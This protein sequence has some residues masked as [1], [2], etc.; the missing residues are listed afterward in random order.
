MSKT[1]ISYL[2]Q[3]FKASGQLVWIGIRPSKNNP[4]VTLE[5][6][7]AD[8]KLGLEGDHYQGGS[9]KRQVTLLQWEHLDVMAS[10]LGEPVKP[11]QLRRNLLIKGINL[12][13]LKNQYF[14]IGEVHFKTTGM[15]H[16]C[17][18]ME[19]ILGHS[20]YNAMRSHGG[21]TAQIIKSGFI[22]KGDLLK[23]MEKPVKHND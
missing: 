3:Q 1:T 17:S 15:C 14:Q 23:V 6:V 8:S 12:I 22:R 9:G 11:E 18:K 19:K 4:L 10:F 20:G 2:T 21:I 7:F 16:P 13:A 5:Q